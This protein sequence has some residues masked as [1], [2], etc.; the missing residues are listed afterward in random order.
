MGVKRIV[1]VLPED[2]GLFDA[3]AVEERLHLT[4]AV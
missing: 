3:L 1:D 4:G 2:L